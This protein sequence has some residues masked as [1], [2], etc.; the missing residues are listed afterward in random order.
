MVL[1]RAWSLCRPDR[2]PY[3]FMML[4]GGRSLLP[5][6]AIDKGNEVLEG[7]FDHVA[8]EM[9]YYLSFPR[10]LVIYLDLEMRTSLQL[11][12]EMV[13]MAEAYERVELSVPMRE[14]FNRYM[15]RMMIIIL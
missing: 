14:R 12:N 5:A 11:M 9:D 4:V 3:E 2:V 15:D 7:Y 10:R 8:T 13:R 6:G 1:D